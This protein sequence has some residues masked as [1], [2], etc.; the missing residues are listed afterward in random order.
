MR[1]LVTG[2]AGFLGSHL[3]EKL[4]NDG[5]EVICLDNFFSGSKDNIRHLLSHENFEVVRHDIQ[6]P[7]SIQVDQIYHLACPASPIYYQ[8]SALDTMKTSVIGTLNVMELARRV[9]ARVLLTS[10]SEIYGNPLEH[11]QSE[12]YWGNVNPIG[13][14]SCY[15]E[16]LSFLLYIVWWKSVKY[17]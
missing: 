9:K 11:P 4:L 15:D 7:I 1:V 3:C 17:Q 8:F 5:C 6:E 10:T 2:G 12:S 13:I 14:R 16:G